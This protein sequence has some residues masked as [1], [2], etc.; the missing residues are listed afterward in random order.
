MSLFLSLL[1]AS[2]ACSVLLG[3]SF[4]ASKSRALVLMSKVMVSSH[5]SGVLYFSGR[6]GG[7]NGSMG[8]YFPSF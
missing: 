1:R 4:L 8:V 2:A 5:F 7:V 3:W 6:W